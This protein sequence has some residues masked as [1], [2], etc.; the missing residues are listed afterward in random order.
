MV[1]SIT[2][3]ARYTTEAVFG[4]SSDAA[5]NAFNF[6]IAIPEPAGGYTAKNLSGTYFVSTFEISGGNAATA[7]SALLLSMQ[8]DGKGNIPGFNLNG[9][10]AN[11]DGGNPFVAFNPGSTTR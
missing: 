4:S 10:A 3:N 1:S 8:P 2:I 6:F 11:V 5:G 7:R 9:H